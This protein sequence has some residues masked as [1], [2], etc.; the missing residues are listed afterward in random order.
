M[1]V[2]TLS[3]VADYLDGKVPGTY[4]SPDNLARMIREAIAVEAGR[5]ERKTAP[6]KLGPEALATVERDKALSLALKATGKRRK[7]RNIRRENA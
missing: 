3:Y 5:E 2:K 7:G 6:P 4:H 1:N